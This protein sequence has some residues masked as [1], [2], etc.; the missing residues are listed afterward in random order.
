MVSSVDILIRVCFTETRFAE[1][2]QCLNAKTSYTVK[3]WSFFPRQVLYV[4]HLLK[5]CL[6]CFKE[7]IPNEFHTK[8]MFLHGS[9]YGVLD[10]ATSDWLE[11]QGFET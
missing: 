4:H 10:M 7:Q 5:T 2:I 11:G 9:R 6:A 8:F 3:G 1:K